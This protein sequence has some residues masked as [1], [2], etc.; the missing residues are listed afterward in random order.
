MT[1]IKTQVTSGGKPFMAGIGVGVENDNGLLTSQI[2]L[3]AQRVAVLDEANGGESVPFVIQGGKT[4]INQALIGDAWIRNA[5][6]ESL[7]AEKVTAGEM[8]A[9][10]IESNSLKSKLANFDT[11]YIKTAHIGLAEVDT[12]RLKSGA[13]VAGN[14]MSVYIAVGRTSGTNWQQVTIDIPYGASGVLIF[15]DLSVSGGPW[16]NQLEIG[17]NLY[18]TILSGTGDAATYAS[19]GDKSFYVGGSVASGSQLTL[20]VYGQRPRDGTCYTTGRVNILV[21]QR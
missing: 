21:I 5:M 12:L 8:S 19:W 9:E 6:I 14:V 16:S 15:W 2:L 20:T 4:Y 1:T 10:R 18:G 11:A 3:S 17:T 13:V 7:R